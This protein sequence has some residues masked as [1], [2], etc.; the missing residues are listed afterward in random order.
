MGDQRQHRRVDADHGRRGSR[1]R[2]PAGRDRRPPT[3]TAAIVPATICSARRLVCVDLK[4]G[5]AQVALP[6]RA[7]PDLGLRPVVGAAAGRHQRRTASRSRPWR[8]RARK[9]S[10]TCSIASPASRCGRSK[11]GR[12]RRATCR[13]RRPRRR[14]RSRPSRRPT[15]GRRSTVDDLIDFTPELRAEALEH[16]RDATSMGPMFL[17][18]GGQQGRRAARGADHIGTPAAA[19]TGPVRRTIRKRTPSM[20][21]RR[22]AGVALIGLDR[23]AGRVLRH[24]LRRRA[25]RGS[26]S[27]ARRPGLRQRGRR[28][29]A[30]TWRRGAGSGSRGARRARRGPAGA[31]G[32]RRHAGAAPAP[33]QRRRRRPRR[34]RPADRQ[35]AVRRALRDQSRS[36]RRSSGRCRTATRRTTS[37]T[38]RADGE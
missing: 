28:G 37:A 32:G 30:R 21:R 27:R 5:A 26:R 14:S 3:T 6:D 35:A 9:R 19:P 10:S 1:P 2:L 8:C 13:A 4:T 33:P 36:R 22:T 12:C 17:P 31:G 24:P 16:R 29:A 20:R 18:A 7:S 25:P 34:S 11:R 15:R 38:S 23:A